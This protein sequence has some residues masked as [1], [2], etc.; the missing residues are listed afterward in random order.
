MKVLIAED[1]RAASARL[2]AY[3]KEWGHQ[4]EVANDGMQAWELFKREPFA[5]LISDWEMPKLSGVELVK[6]VREKQT[7]YVYILLLTSKSSNKDIVEGMEAGADDFVSKPFDKNVLRVRVRAGERIL[8]LEQHLARLNDAKN[9]IHEGVTT[10]TH[11]RILSHTIH[12][13]AEHYD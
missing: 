1:D 4:A 10:L 5:I 13:Q 2:S 9:L 11:I 3:V 8:Q 7:N 6:R 12:R